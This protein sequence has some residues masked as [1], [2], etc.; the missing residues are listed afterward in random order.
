MLVNKVQHFFHIVQGFKLGVAMPRSLQQFQFNPV[1][2][3]H[4]FQFGRE[5]DR[6]LNRDGVI[7]RAMLQEKGGSSGS[8]V[9]FRVEALTLPFHVIRN[10]LLDD[11]S[12]GE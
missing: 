4:L 9:G 6:L 7:L 2:S 3:E 5:I 12:S 10:E 8:D 1:L 11:F